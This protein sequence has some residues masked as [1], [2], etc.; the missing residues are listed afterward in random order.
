MLLSLLCLA[1]AAFAQEAPYTEG[2]VWSISFVK[3]EPGRGDDYIKNL[4]GMWRRVNGEAIKEGLVLS[5][6]VIGAPAANTSDWDLMLLVE[7]KNMAALDGAEAKFRAIVNK[8]ASEEEVE[9]GVETRAK[10]REIVGEKLG[11]EL[12]F[13]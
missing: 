5:Y 1:S 9:T 6:K 4:S 11:R 8:L 7:F 3:V 2:T 12:H 10:I 13:K